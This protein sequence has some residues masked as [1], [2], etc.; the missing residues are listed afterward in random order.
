[1]LHPGEVSRWQG[2]RLLDK[3]SNGSVSDYL[4]EL[5]ALPQ[6]GVSQVESSTPLPGEFDTH[7][8]PEQKELSSLYFL[9][10]ISMRRLLNRVHHLLYARST[11]TAL[12]PAKFPAVVRELDHQLDEW[13]EVLPRALAFDVDLNAVNGLQGTMS[14]PQTE[15]G[16][17]LRQRYLTCR[18]VIYRPYLMWTLSGVQTV[19]ATNAPLQQEA[20]NGS[21][22][23]LDSC[24]LH[25]LNL[26][27]FGQTCL[28]DT[29]ICSLSYVSHPSFPHR[30]AITYVVVN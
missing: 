11:G 13:R 9:A 20:L 16:S 30:P 8:S 23:C 24:L 10:C 29:W 2:K 6:S 18:S 27:G 4:A 14:T 1:M 19:N 28:V 15:A 5:P 26:R 3:L 21:K 12:N 22:I 25:I 7:Y 17:F